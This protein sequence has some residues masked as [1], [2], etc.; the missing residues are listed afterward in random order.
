[1]AGQLGIGAVDLGVV[2]V[3]PVDPGAQVVGHQP[4]WRAAEERKRGDVRGGPGVLV[5]AQHRPHEQVPRAAQHH[6]KRPH[7][8]AAPTGRVDPAAQ[9]AVVDLGFLARPDLLA[10]HHH[11]AAAQL[12]GQHRGH[13][14]PQ[15]RHAGRKALLVTQP[16]VDGGLGHPGGQQLLDVVVM[17]AD[18]RP[19]HLP[20]PGVDQVREPA[21]D[22]LRPVRRRHRRATRAKARSDRRGQVL[23][24]RLAVHSQAGRHFADRPAR[25]PVDQDLGHVDHDER[26]PRHR[27]PRSVCCLRGRTC[28]IA[29]T[30]PALV[31]PMGNSVS[32]GWGIT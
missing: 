18:L 17:A 8:P 9:I 22:Q 11:L 7:P 14:P 25:I 21:S 2:Q 12:L 26:P 27:L 24:D 20:Q 4:T 1:V 30:T 13:I 32:A 10:Q 16:L 28:L 29:R 15:R 23:A 6:H 19:G 5:H 31:V 3:G